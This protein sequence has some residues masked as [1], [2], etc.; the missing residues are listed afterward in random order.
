M[1][2]KEILTLAFGIIVA[3]AIANPL[4]FREALRRTEIQILRDV[5]R[6][7]NWGNPSIFRHHIRQ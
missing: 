5:G 1:P 7:N 6:T 2:I 3:L 4:H